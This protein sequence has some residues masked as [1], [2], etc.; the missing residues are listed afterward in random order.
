MAKI[1]V[2]GSINLDYVI[3]TDSLPELG[4]TIKGKTFFCSPGGKGANQAVAA[5]RLGGKVTM[6]GSVGTD[7]NG[8][9]LKSNLEKEGI[10][11]THVNDIP[12]IPTGAAFI[13][14]CQG[15][16]RIL[17]ISGAN[18]YTNNAYMKSKI[19]QLLQADCILFQFETPLELLEELVPILH[20][21]GKTIIVNPAPAFKLNQEII[22]MITYLTPNEH[23]YQLVLDTSMSCHEVIRKYPNKLII[24]RGE[25]GILYW[26]DKKEIIIPSIKVTPVDTTGAGDTFSGAFALAI[27][28]GMSLPESI[29][30]GTVAAGISI[31]QKG[32]QSGMP[33]RKDV[34][35]LLNKEVRNHE[36]NK[37][38]FTTG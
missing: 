19:D 33:Y 38:L 20:N 15:D 37:G 26:D 28:E 9:Y 2:V 1:A 12:D 21:A 24:T 10:D 17:I 16:N 36:D 3:E 35:A 34:D 22:D 25:K 5:A 13:E 4:E 31:T 27:S 23:E 29:R 11:V 18:D 32:A 30:F 6:F 7:I 14:L 8:T